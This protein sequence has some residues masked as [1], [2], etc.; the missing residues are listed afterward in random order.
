[1]L[2][3]FRVAAF[4]ASAPCGE[5]LR[6]SQ[7]LRM[8]PPSNGYAGMRFRT[9]NPALI[10]T[11]L[12]SKWPAWIRGLEKRATPGPTAA[13]IVTL[14]SATSRFAAG[15]ARQFVIPWRDRV[16]HRD[17]LEDS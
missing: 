17:Q 12:R 10:Q 11:R 8:R 4:Q 3:D 1:M 9:V 15:P 2:T 16:A 14:T 6:A 13:I 7:A 5:V